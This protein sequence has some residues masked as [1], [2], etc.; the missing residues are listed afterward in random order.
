MY[1]ARGNE[2]AAWAAMAPNLTKPEF[3]QLIWRLVGDDSSRT[4][5]RFAAIG[6][7]TL[8]NVLVANETASHRVL[9]HF[10]DSLGHCLM[11]D[12]DTVSGD[13]D[14]R[15]IQRTFANRFKLRPEPALKS[16]GVEIRFASMELAVGSTRL[17]ICWYA[18]DSTAHL[19][20]VAR[21]MPA[22]QRD[23]SG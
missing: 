1:M 3:D 12:S 5:D 7:A 9:V 2:K 14:S 17:P 4:E 6:E 18:P 23:A 16:C 20:V 15:T 10:G 13:H 8:C 11:F 22:R 19:T 21:L